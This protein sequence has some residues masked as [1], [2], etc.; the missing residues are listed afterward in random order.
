MFGDRVP[1]P[2]LNPSFAFTIPATGT[3]PLDSAAPS[4]ID[5]QGD[6]TA[7]AEIPD[8]GARL[9]MLILKHPEATAIKALYRDLGVAGPPMIIPGPELRYRALVETPAGLKELG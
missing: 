5:H 1:L 3:L 6:P 7:M 2:P 9:R 4:I 8:L